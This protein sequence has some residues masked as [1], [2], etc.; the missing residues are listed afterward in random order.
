MQ[1]IDCLGL[2]FVVDVVVQVY[3]VVVQVDFYV[4]IDVLWKIFWVVVLLED[5]V[6]VFGVGFEVVI[7]QVNERVG[8][9][10]FCYDVLVVSG[11]VEYEVFVGDKVFFVGY[12]VCVQ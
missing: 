4:E 11:V 7:V 10:L 9:Y 5:G 6:F 2:R 8:C 12:L 3:V 1:G